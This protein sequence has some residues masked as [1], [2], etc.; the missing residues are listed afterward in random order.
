[1]LAFQERIAAAGAGVR[2]NLARARNGLSL[3]DIA[4]GLA[5]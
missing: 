5:R 1:M 3:F 2:P 4:L